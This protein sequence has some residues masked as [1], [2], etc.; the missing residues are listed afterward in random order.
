MEVTLDDGPICQR[1]GPP[2]QDGEGDQ[3]KRLL[4]VMAALES[5]VAA[6]G[7]WSKT[8]GR[9]LNMPLKRRMN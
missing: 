5:T 2:L 6:R 7:I 1:S 8:A 3:I 9:L 4:L